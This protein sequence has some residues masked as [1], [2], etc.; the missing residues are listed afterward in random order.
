MTTSLSDTAPQLQ[1]KFLGEPR[2]LLDSKPL[3]LPPSKKTRALLAYL[4]LNPRT[5]RR[6]LLCEL[7]WEVPDDPRGS[8]R[9]SLSKIRRLVDSDEKARIV[10]DRSSV[11]MDTEGLDIDIAHLHHLVKTGLEHA[12]LSELIEAAD[13]YLGEFLQGLELPDFHEFYIWCIA[14]R[15]Q[16][17]KSQTLL[18][19]TLINR[20]HHEPAQALPYARQLAALQP[21]DEAVRAELIGFLMKLDCQQEAEQQYRLGQKMLSEVGAQSSGLL[22]GAMQQDTS[23]S[24]PTHSQASTTPAITKP[25]PINAP[26]VIGRQQELHSLQQ[27]YQS[28]ANDHQAKLLLLRGEPGIGKSHLL[29][30]AAAIGQAAGAKVLLAGTFESDIVRPFALWIDALRYD[31]GNADTSLFNGDNHQDRDQLFTG[32]S[33]WVAEQCQ[34]QALV[35]VFDDIQWSDESSAAVLHYVLRINRQRPLLVVAASRDAE[36]NDNRAMLQAIR[37]LRGDKLLQEIKLGPLPGNE[38]QQLISQHAPDVDV[39]RLSEECGGNPLFAIELARAE[40]EGDSGSSLNEL[41]QERLS[42]LEASATDM[43]LW[44]SVLAPHIDI[45]SLQ[46]VTDLSNSELDCALE[47][48]EQQGLLHTHERGFDFPHHLI[49]ASIYKQISPA[50]CQAMHRRVAEILE[51]DTALDLKL[52]ADLA[53]HAAKSGDPALA[54]RAMVSAGRLSLRFFANED[55]LS[56]AQRGMKYAQ[57]LSPAEQVCLT[58]ELS[59]VEMTAAPSADWNA[60]AE[61]YVALAEQALDHGALPYARLGYQM[62]SYVR[63]INGQW[64]DAERDSLQAERVTRGSNDEEHIVGMAETAKCLAL[65]ERDLSHADAML[66]EA[67]SI[68]KRRQ[69]SSAT[70]QIALGILRYY[71]NDLPKSEELLLEARTIYKSQGD[72]INEYQANEYLVMVNIEA[73]RYDVA[74]KRCQQLVEIGDKLR[75]GSE[76][77]FAKAIQAL[78]DYALNNEDEGLD[79]PL[80]QLRVA[81][82]KHRLAYVLTRAARFDIEQGKIDTAI[83]RAQEALEYTEL[84]DRPSEK[85][86]ANIALAKAHKHNNDQAAS[87]RHLAAVVELNKSMVANW[88][89]NRATELL[90]TVNV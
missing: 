68:A 4:A 51:V 31:S 19:T 90:G 49:G 85:M 55:A 86:L 56:L 67:S 25:S 16:V 66:M 36:L 61:K 30:A 2:V 35:M 18:L 14:E 27:C 76:A 21:Y 3:S 88:A 52:A 33:D 22:R 40:T 10:A 75:E 32:L 82:A 57:Q 38:L 65:L 28:V 12:E 26:T 69:I 54:A 1:L 34:Q 39:L 84:L 20:L 60:S 58:L 29:Q 62:A 78:C 64:S 59:E 8:L 81:D 47:I 63:W 43:L 87:E 17:S 23:A 73:E 13:H 89:R 72:R 42:R 6:E 77:P 46:R 24:M 45:K 44:A 11:S 9:W 53:H 41:I 50:R 74:Q 80:Q 7:L 83:A 15:E 71:E 70:I 48:A 79:E 37:G 5:F